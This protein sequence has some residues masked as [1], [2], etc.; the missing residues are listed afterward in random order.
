MLEYAT[1]TSLQQIPA[2]NKY[3]K[4]KH[5]NVVMAVDV[6]AFQHGSYGKCCGWTFMLDWSEINFY[7]I[8]HHNVLHYIIMPS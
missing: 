1:Y 6:F 8:I 3:E 4:E 2:Y 7:T 5:H